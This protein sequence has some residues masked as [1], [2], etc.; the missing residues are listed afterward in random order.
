MRE[1]RRRF[2]EHL[3]FLCAL[4]LA[5]GFV[6]QANAW[7]MVAGAEEITRQVTITAHGGRE[8]V[9]RMLDRNAMTAWKT[10]SEKEVVIRLEFPE[11]LEEGTLYLCW[12]AM[13]GTWRV[14]DDQGVTVHEGQGDV[15]H[16]AIPFGRSGA[17]S[18]HALHGDKQEVSISELYVFKGAGFPA[19]AQAWERTEG[20]VDLMVVA[21][22]PDDELIYYGGTLPYYAGERG[23]NVQVVYLTC[24]REYRRNELLNA[25]WTCGVRNYPLIGAFPDTDAKS[26]RQALSAW[27]GQAAQR[28]VVEAIRAYRPAV[29]VGHD[30][31]GEYGHGAHMAVAELLLEG[32]RLAA[33]PAAFPESAAA[34]GAWQ[35]SKLYLHLYPDNPVL[36]D[37]QQPL[38]AFGGSTAMMVAQDAFTHYASQHKYWSVKPGGRYDNAKFGLAF[39]A[40]GMDSLSK[41]FFEN[42]PVNREQNAEDAP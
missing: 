18:I 42:I 3:V 25:L 15:A 37:W 17:L 8:R 29:I 24:A 33:D 7:Q 10:F 31:R 30:P 14:E 36:M 12:A 6:C 23:L 5:L 9:A 41:D 32:V 13:P 28:F 19:Q 2:W 22:H 27:G 35:A 1:I 40:L 4:C 21:A 34:D 16:I 26:A 20:P 38:A 11:T 39:S